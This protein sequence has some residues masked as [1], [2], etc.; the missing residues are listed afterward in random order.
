[1]LFSIRKGLDL[2]HP[3]IE[4]IQDFCALRKLLTRLDINCV[5]DVGANRGQ[6]AHHLRGIGFAGDIISFEPLPSEFAALSQSFTSDQRWRGLQLALGEH[7]GSAE[8][9]F[10]PDS[11]VMSSMLNLVHP[12]ANLQRQSI[13]VRRLDGL[14]PELVANLDGPRVLLKLDTQG[15]DLQVFRGAQGCLDRLAGI[16]AE[17][18][19]TRN[20]EDAPDY[21]EALA[22]Y[23]HA[24]FSLDAL[25]VNSLSAS[26]GVHEFNCLMS[27]SR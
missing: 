22:T 8:I 1:M 13:E 2:S 12:P 5:L 9:N 17:V 20:Y 19:V 27:R 23:E 11:P 16:Y 21:H 7:D 24:G 15:Y 6:F 26:G 3:S 25:S 14:F 18:T 10:V 4:R